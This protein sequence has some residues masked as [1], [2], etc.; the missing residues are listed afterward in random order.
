MDMTT[1]TIESYVESSPNAGLKRIILK[2]PNTADDGDAVTVTLADYGITTLLTV[3]GWVQTT[4]DSVIVAEAPTT[5]VSSGVLTITL[6]S[7]GGSNKVRI[8]EIVGKSN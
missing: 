2:T 5:S 3:Q 7:V 1:T 8:F 6:G 4:A